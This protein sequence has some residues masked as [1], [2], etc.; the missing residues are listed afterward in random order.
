MRQCWPLIVAALMI[1]VPASAQ[2]A[3]GRIEVTAVDATGAVLPGVTVELTG[4]QMATA[5]TGTAGVARF[6]SLAPGTYQVRATLQGFSEYLNKSVE[7]VAGGNVQLSAKMTVAGVK[8]Q[9]Q[10]TAETPVIDTK[11]TSDSTNVTL[12]ELQNVPTARDPWVV[13]QTVPG[14]I[15]DRVNV[16]GSES[17]QQSGYQAKGASGADAT[18]SMDGIPITDMAATGASSVYYDFDMFQEMNVTTGGSDMTSSTGGVHLNFVLKS[19]TNTPHGSTRVYF[20]N[21]GMQSNN[22]DPALATALGSP[23]GKGNRTQQYADYGFEVGGPI[24]KDRL[25]GWGSMGKT[26]VRIVTIRQT[27]DRT[28]LKNAG[29]KLT[30]QVT[31]NLRAGFTYFYANKNKF[32][33]SAS[34]TRPPAT[35]LDQKGPSKFS[36]FEANYVVGNDLFLTVRG[37]HFPTGFQLDPEG[38]LNAQIY[39]DDSGMWHGSYWN[40]KSDRPQN[41][42]EAEGS[43]FKGNHEVKFGYSWRKVSVNSSSQT[44]GNQI[45]TYYNGYPDLIAGVASYWASA[46]TAHY[47]ALWA[48]DT[49][50]ADRLTLNAGIRFDWQDDGTQAVSEPAVPGFEQ[51]LPAIQSVAVPNAVKW[52]SASPRIAVTYALDQSHKTLLRASYALF[53]SQLANGTSSQISTVQYRYISFSAV[54]TNGNGLADPNEINYNDI[55]SWTGFDINNPGQLST[56]INTIHDYKVPKTHEILFGVD[57]ELMPNFGLSATFTYRRMVDFNWTPRIGVRSGD[58]VQVGTLTGSGLPGGSSYSVPYYAVDPSMLSPGAL[59]GG[60]ELTARQ[61]YHQRYMGLEVSATKR[62]SNRW[63]ARLG[64]STNSH[65]EYF[66]DPA[67]AIQDPTPGPSNPLVNGGYVVTASSGSGKSGIYQLLPKFQFIANGMYQA[68]YGI[69]L[70]FNLLTR[71][72]FGQPWYQSHVATGDLF[73]TNKNVLLVSDVGANR[74]PTVTTFDFRLGKVFKV[75]RADINFDLDIFNLFNSGT[76]LGRQYDKR[77]TGPTGFDQV[78]E[79]MNPR[80][81]RI[82]LRVN[83]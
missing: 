39:Q 26:D 7:V 36:K 15:T 47:K 71:Q 30:G 18:W 8:E 77:L 31:R 65:R 34:A 35:T 56:P 73:G 42:V 66:T 24:V 74:L 33:R 43:F 20:E 70:G 2:I 52:N 80:I 3:T 57:H 50:T 64:F 25:W 61:G 40:Y 23:N 48:G 67:T 45:I 82:G 75:S 78:L 10:V 5:V 13:L 60:T 16:G 41:T 46:A 37:A 49:M 1:A 17:G 6:L 9:V 72:G 83:F 69:D 21:D 55:L 38:G 81:M 19:G 28:I 53:A 59:A 11:K 27:P 51:Y 58:Y 29:F 76:V 62:L 44:P 4:Q 12:A 79:I 68:P 22:M 63:M 14:I 54:D 32:G